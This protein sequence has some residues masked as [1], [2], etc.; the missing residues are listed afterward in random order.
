[1]LVLKIAARIGIILLFSIVATKIPGT[2]A[3]STNLAHKLCISFSKRLKNEF[4]KL[5][6]IVVRRDL[7]CDNMDSANLRKRSSLVAGDLTF[8]STVS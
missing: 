6:K 7:D 5:S 4:L 3:P 8:A 2:K 1:M